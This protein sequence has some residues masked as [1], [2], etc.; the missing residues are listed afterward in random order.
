MKFLCIMSLEFVCSFYQSVNKKRNIGKPVATQK[1]E[2]LPHF[3]KYKFF[4]EISFNIILLT[5]DY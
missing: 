3:L 2:K 1:L 5:S 4:S